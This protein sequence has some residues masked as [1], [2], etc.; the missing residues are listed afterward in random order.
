[1]SRVSIEDTPIIKKADSIYKQVE[2]LMKVI[3]EE[4]DFLQSQAGLMMSDSMMICAKLV[5]ASGV[6]LYSIKMQNAA[7]IRQCVMDLYVFLSGLRYH[8]GFTSKDYVELIRRE[9][10]EFRLLF[11]EWVANFDKSDYIWDEWELFN[12]PGA[13]PPSDDDYND[14]I[15][16]DDFDS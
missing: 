8:E 4:D 14:P 12:P 9:I 3:P 16:W 7:I 10:E 6:D 11:I 5:G 13:I 1:M 2:A 15:N